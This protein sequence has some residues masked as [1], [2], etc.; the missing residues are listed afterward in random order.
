VCGAWRS[1][2]S[3]SGQSPA[4]DSVDLG[5]DRDHRVA[6]AVEFAQALALGRLDHQRAGD[7]KAHR[8]GVE[9][10]VHQPLGDVVD[11]DAGR[12]GDRPRRS[13]MH[14]W[15]TRPRSP[16]VEHRVVLEALRRRSWPRGSPPRGPVQPVA[17]H[18][19]D[20]HPRDRQDAR[21]P[22]RRRRHRARPAGR[23]GAPGARAGTAPGAHRHRSGPP[24]PPPP[25][26]MQN[27][28]CR[29]RWL[30]SAPKR[31]GRAWPTSALRLAPSMYTWPP[32]SWTTAHSSPTVASN[33]PCVDG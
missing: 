5:S 3:S 2:L 25:W 19:L 15:A 13:R 20:V 21:R 22:E 16:R 30:T 23:L 6:E 9:A 33:T 17:A 11:G 1:G 24:G 7:R 18:H 8:R 29:L 27:V 10:V 12:L 26:G 4:T 14:S 31:P 32:A 28:L